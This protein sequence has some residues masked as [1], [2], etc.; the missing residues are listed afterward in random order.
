MVRG[1]YFDAKSSVSRDAG[2]AAAP[3]GRWRLVVG[4]R[5]LL[6]DPAAVQ[7]SDR[8]GAIPRRVRCPDGG[9]FETA[10]NDGIDALLGVPAGRHAGL[11]HTLERRWGV[12]VAALFAVVLISAGAIRYGIPALAGFAAARLPPQ[13]DLR[14]GAQ[15]LQIL[16]RS[17]LRP[18][19]LPLQRQSWLSSVF[20]RMTA[21]LDD[22][23]VYRLEFRSGPLGPNALALPSGIIVITDDL[24]NL[25]RHDEELMAV[26]AHEIGHV[27]GRHALR[28]IIQG[29]GVSAIALA[30]LGDVSSVSAL[31]GAAPVLLE[32]RHSRELEREADTFA[33]A[34]LAQHGVAEIRF[35]DILCRM[36]GP[37]GGKGG[38]AAAF[39]STHPALDERA[40]C[41]AAEA[42]K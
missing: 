33:R 22:G 26:L 17:V 41:A 29:A 42:A 34:W 27:R 16:D 31:A 19:R 6:L 36:A 38:T 32:T 8:I 10:D 12:A 28:H 13:I 15:A 20:A 4:D 39:L 21:D 30:V 3:A 18:S 23:H 9:E 2:L 35:D 37:A 5:Q 14:I 40:R 24:V 25:A 11:V 7:V 1:R